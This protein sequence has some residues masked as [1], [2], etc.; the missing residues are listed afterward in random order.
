MSTETAAVCARV[1]AFADVMG[2]PLGLFPNDDSDPCGPASERV[3]LEPADLRH[4]LR[5]AEAAQA[6]ID[7]RVWVE[8]ADA[9]WF[10]STEEKMLV[11]RENETP[12]AAVLA[13]MS[14]ES[15]NV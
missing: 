13:A 4:L 3:W 14:P 12:L 8:K 5:C 11:V 10:V 9:S 15:P 2:G 6:L 7:G 1:K